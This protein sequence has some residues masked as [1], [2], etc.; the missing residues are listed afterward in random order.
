MA[1]AVAAGVQGG[2]THEAVIQ[3]AYQGAVY[4]ES[5]GADIPSASVSK[6]ILLAKEIVNRNRT[7]GISDTLDELVGLLGAGMQAVESIPWRKRA[8]LQNSQISNQ[9]GVTYGRGTLI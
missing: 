8:S 9:P 6:R 4:G 1:A 7:R 5:I 2:S 3:L